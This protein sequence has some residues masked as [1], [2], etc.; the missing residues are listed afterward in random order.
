MISFGMSNLVDRHGIEVKKCNMGFP[1]FN[2]FSIVLS[3]SKPIWAR[4]CVVDGKGKH[5]TITLDKVHKA[6]HCPADQL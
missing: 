2:G 3:Q 4:G 5:V 6:C 1:P